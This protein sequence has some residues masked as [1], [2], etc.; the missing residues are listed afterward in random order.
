MEAIAWY[1]SFHIDPSIWGIYVWDEALEAFAANTFRTLTGFSD[2]EKLLVAWQF[3]IDHELF[4]Y[5]TDVASA[6]ME[7]AAKRAVYIPYV[8][9]HPDLSSP[10]CQKEEALAN[11]RA[12][13]RLPSA[14]A[15][16]C[17]AAGMRRQPPGYRFW[18]EYRA[19]KPFTLGKRELGLCIHATTGFHW[20]VAPFDWFFDERRSGAG[21]G[22]IPFRW[23]RSPRHSGKPYLLSYARPIEVVEDAKFLGKLRRLPA[24]VQWTW[25]NKTKPALES[26]HWSGTDFK[27]I[28]RD[29]YRCRVGYSYRTHF[30]RIKSD[31]F[32]AK[33]IKPREGA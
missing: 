32:M 12:W 29:L 25:R 10:V 17:A 8:R 20:A 13:R 27:K 18:T 30:T 33:E 23:V 21:T 22:T 15:K 9:T 6:Q 2:A 28:G 5:W 7:F 11:A 3:L 19:P 24:N 4:H 26:G 16:A 1:I 14:E 31:S